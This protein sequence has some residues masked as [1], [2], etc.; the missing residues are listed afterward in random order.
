MSQIQLNTLKLIHGLKFSKTSLLR[1]LLSLLIGITILLITDKTPYDLYFQIS[2]AKNTSRVLLLSIAPYE[3][4]IIGEKMGFKDVDLHRWQPRL[5]DKILDKLSHGNPYSIGVTLSFMHQ[6]VSSLF[7]LK[8]HETVYWS[9]L[10]QSGKAFRPP[11]LP[12]E[13]KN[14]GASYIHPDGDGITRRY[15][16][17]KEQPTLLEQIAKTK[18]YKK[19]GGF[20]INFRGKN[21]VFEHFSLSD[22]MIDLY[23]NA[24]LSDKYVL[25][26]YDPRYDQSFMTPIGPMPK[27]ELLANVLDNILESRWIR[28]LP[29]PLSI[30]YLIFLLMVAN[31]LV[32][33]GLSNMTLVF[34]FCSYGVL[35]TSLSIWLLNKFYFYMP[36]LAP[37]CLLTTT[38]MIFWIS[39][40]TLKEN[41]SRL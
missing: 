12:Q 23:S 3:W 13:N 32:S 1:N 4:D 18:V 6:R 15:N 5:W 30:T 9:S 20:I 39:Q 38:L 2:S 19:N 36:I 17:L 33:M 21:R 26:G 11:F 40:F 22:L 14:F 10:E 28:N 31:L 29:L 25:I 24:V 37:L 7:S 8:K 16:F 41:A 34:S 27:L 35:L